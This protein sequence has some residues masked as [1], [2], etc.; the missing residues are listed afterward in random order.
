MLPAD[1][2]LFLDHRLVEFCAGMPAELKLK[3]RRGKYI[4]RQAARRLVP[5][6]VITRKKAG[7]NAPVSHWLAGSWRQL[8]E[9]AF[10]P[11]SLNSFGLLNPVA[12]N[13]LFQEHLQGLRDHGY[14]L[15]TLLM[16]VL[17]LKK[18][19]PEVA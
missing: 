11:A 8:A 3:G 18:V 13:R 1:Q 9:E 17:W 15:F 19:R 16:L 7:F 4:L 10:S 5:Q 2:P 12:V 14:L 6:Q